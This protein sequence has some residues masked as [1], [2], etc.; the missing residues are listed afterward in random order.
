MPKRLR[1][2]TRQPLDKGV[3]DINRGLSQKQVDERINKKYVNDVKIGTSKSVTSII[4]S[5]TCSLFNLMCILIFIWIL[6]IA[7]DF[8]D[9]KNCTF[10]VIIFINI[11]IGIVQEL[12][13]KRTMDKL[14]LLSS[15]KIKVLRSGK[16]QDIHVN[17]ILMDDIML[18]D[19]GNQVCSDSEILEGSVEVNESLITGESDSI[20][21]TKGDHL[22]SGSFIVSGKCKVKVEH[23]GEENYVQKLAVEAKQFKRQ[24]SQLLK[25]LTLIM[26]VLTVIIVIYAV[27]IFLNNFNAS[28][29]EIRA[30][31]N[32][33][34]GLFYAIGKLDMYTKAEI[35]SA[36]VDS[37][38]PTATGLI[39]MIPAGLFL[40]TSIALAVG[41]VRLAKKNALVQGL[42]SIETLAR[43]NMLCLDKTG[44]ITDGTMC[45]NSLVLTS[46]DYTVESVG[47]IVRAM[48]LA[49]EDNN[50]TARALLDYFKVGKQKVVE[51][52][53][54]FSSD[55]KRSI[56]K[57]Q[58]DDMYIIGAPEYVM[59][60]LNEKIAKSIEEYQ[61]AGYRCLLLA[62]TSDKKAIAQRDSVGAI[63]PIAVIVIEDNIKSDAVE[64]IKYFKEN[65]VAVRVI[66]GDNPITVSEVAARV[67][68]DNAD[69]FISLQN[70]SDEEIKAIAMDYTVFGR[71][72][73]NQKKLLVQ[74]FKSH[75]NTVAMT[76]DGINDILALKEADCSIAMANGSE[77]TRNIAQLVLMDSNF[78]SMPSVVGEG[79]RVV[80][81]IERASSLFLMKTLFTFIVMFVLVF[82][83]MKLPLDPV[84]LSFIS[85]FG[86]GIPSFVLALEPNNNRIEGKFVSNVLKKIVPGSVTMVICVLLVILF[87]NNGLIVVSEEQQK[88]MVMVTM[89]I[90]YLTM[91]YY[92]CKPMNLV[93]TI[94][95]VAISVLSLLVI[96]IAPNLPIYELN[97]F[98]VARLDTVP[99]VTALM[100]VALIALA[101][102]K[103]G[104]IVVSKIDLAWSEAN[105]E[106]DI[107]TEEILADEMSSECEYAN[108]TT[109]DIDDDTNHS[110]SRIDGR[111]PGGDK[112]NK[113]KDRMSLFF[114]KLFRLDDKRER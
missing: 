26:K 81:N 63:T 60:G 107:E 23:I 66:S 92:V 102:M 48:E 57:F 44:T 108:V 32:E 62:G 101:L 24:P 11:T 83:Q 19:A 21:K 77:A 75:G 56:V 30:F 5:N 64:T 94:L 71:V 14:S 59:T 110:I 8:N 9:V 22:M 16:E 55:R 85:L 99:I 69:K 73:P 76:G 31:E 52:T 29:L 86:V 6:T 45:V 113:K 33:R 67:G 18:L 35:Y 114:K 78:G 28:L 61:L 42:Y 53:V 51:F 36:Y 109:L 100:S 38:N 13:A 98:N 103:V 82:M 74:I 41:V 70:M 25:S 96:T 12:R 1:N 43:V 93:R 87:T 37:V 46:K 15:P 7:K 20:S 104:N 97:I 72:N 49:L 105:E 54:P 50:A 58:D 106:I 65:D 39:G 68:I 89:A 2:K 34:A 3:V 17:E 40:L 112:D 111:V 84:Q 80:N 90:C 27:P 88:T 47:E 4:I 79:R 91:I 95:M 10:M